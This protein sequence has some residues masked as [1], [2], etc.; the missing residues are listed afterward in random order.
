MPSTVGASLLS[1]TY[2]IRIDSSDPIIRLLEEIEKHLADSAAP[3]TILFDKLPILM[4]ILAPF[5]PLPALG[6]SR[7]EWE[8]LIVKFR[9]DPFHRVRNMMVCLP[10]NLAGL[11]TMYIIH[12]SMV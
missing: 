9:D 10:L 3:L 12:S 1:L 4:S 2:G 7:K 8:K 11:M 6:K 5:L